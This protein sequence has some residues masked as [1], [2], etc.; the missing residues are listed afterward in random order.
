M[1]VNL[2]FIS[3][4]YH[5]S[6]FMFTLNII[7]QPL[8][9]IV[10]IIA[11]PIL[12]SSIVKLLFVHFSKFTPL[13]PSWSHLC[14][15][16]IPRCIES[17]QPYPPEWCIG[18]HVLIACLAI[19]CGLQFL[20]LPSGGGAALHSSPPLGFTFGFLTLVGE[21]QLDQMSFNPL[22]SLPRN[23]LLELHQESSP[24]C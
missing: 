24:G 3:Y 4:K 10:N 9:F 1:G 22:P 23:P 16:L 19:L 11:H 20:A 17:L 14:F 8:L 18:A 15:F 2:K 13:Y 21:L 6:T 7:V 12:C 5:H